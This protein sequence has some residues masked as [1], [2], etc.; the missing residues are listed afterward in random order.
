M[1]KNHC[2]CGCGVVIPE[3]GTRGK[4]IFF[5]WGHNSRIANKGKHRSPET[6]FKKGVRNSWKGGIKLSPH[7]YVMI[8]KPDYHKTTKGYVY[9]HRLVMEQHLGRF[10]TQYE[11]VHHINGIKTDN[12]IENLELLSR[13]E[14]MRL[15]WQKKK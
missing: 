7:G 8:F 15:H 14:H 11:D 12:R 10:L 3:F 9:E 4:P 13:S 6:E 5:K 2:K 1:S